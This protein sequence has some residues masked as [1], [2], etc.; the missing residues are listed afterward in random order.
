M[1][2]NKP[3]H[4]AHD[5]KNCACFCHKFKGFAIAFIGLMVLLGNLQILDQ[6]LVGILWPV[7]LILIGLK[8]AMGKGKCK[9]CKRA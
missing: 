4:C 6:H 9:C 3:E 5:G 8:K 7:A 1:E 2:E